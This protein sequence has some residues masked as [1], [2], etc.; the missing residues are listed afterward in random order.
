MKIRYDEPSIRMSIIITDREHIYRWGRTHR[1]H[2]RFSR[3]KWGPSWR[4]RRSVGCITPTNHGLPERRESTRL[5]AASPRG[6]EISVQTVLPCTPAPRRISFGRL[7]LGRKLPRLCGSSREMAREVDRTE[8]S[9][10]TTL[11]FDCSPISNTSTEGKAGAFRLRRDER[12]GVR[13]RWFLSAQVHLQIELESNDYGVLL[14]D[15]DLYMKA[16]RTVYLS[17]RSDFKLGAIIAQHRM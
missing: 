4:Y 1:S 10:G 13:S 14:S 12:V 17:G 8:F 3:R 11:R 9:L 5:R 15:K 2:E 7:K 6:F 16:K